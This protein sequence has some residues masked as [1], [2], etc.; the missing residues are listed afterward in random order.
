[1]STQNPYLTGDEDSD[2][3]EDSNPQSGQKVVGFIG[4]DGRQIPDELAEALKKYMGDDV[5]VTSSSI[6]YVVFAVSEMQSFF[7]NILN[8]NYESPLLLALYDVVN[9]MSEGVLDKYLSYYEIRQKII[10]IHT[11]KFY[12]N[13]LLE[14]SERSKSEEEHAKVDFYLRNY[15]DYLDWKL[16]KLQNSYLISCEDLGIDVDNSLLEFGKFDDKISKQLY[17]ASY[18]TL[19]IKNRLSPENANQN[20]SDFKD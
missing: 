11:I 13:T 4:P 2:L 1:L 10:F 17:V 14:M 5:V 12:S 16:N 8:S 7:S 3:F 20:E 19:I 6:P 18:S 9:H 15:N